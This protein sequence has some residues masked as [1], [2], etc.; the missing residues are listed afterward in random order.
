MATIEQTQYGELHYIVKVDNTAGGA[1]QYDLV[2]V[3]NTQDFSTVFGSPSSTVKNSLT[4]WFQQQAKGI[5]DFLGIFSTQKTAQALI[6]LQSLSPLWASPA[7]QRQFVGGGGIRF[8]VDIPAGQ[9]VWFVWGMTASIDGGLALLGGAGAPG[10][11]TNGGVVRIASTP[12]LAGTAVVEGAG[13][14]D[15]ALPLQSPIPSSSAGVTGL[16]VQIA[17]SCTVG[18]ATGAAFVLRVTDA[19]GSTVYG[20][21]SGTLGIGDTAAVSIVGFDGP[22]SS[23]TLYKLT[24]EVVSAPGTGVT[25]DN[26]APWGQPEGKLVLIGNYS[27]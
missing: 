5:S 8:Y 13:Q 19:A 10:A 23:S 26:A 9:T 22:P 11:G 4:K 17:G 24:C 3:L 15:L 16:A 25:V 12:V 21:V 20:S 2:S 14:V 7:I 6:S 27:T 18:S 1:M